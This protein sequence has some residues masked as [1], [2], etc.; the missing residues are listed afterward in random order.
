[1]DAGRLIARVTIG[2]LFVGHGTQKLF[3]WF[4]GSGPEGTAQMMDKLE[5][6]P[7]RRNALAAGASEAA[8]GA[9]LALGALTPLAGALLSGTMFTAIRKVHL[10][11]G[12][13]NTGGG[14]E[15][16]L[17]VV[18]A[19]AA[20]VEC[21]PG[22]PSV[23]RALGI[24]TSG[25]GWGLAAIA[26]GAAGSALAIEAGRRATEPAAGVGPEQEPAGEE[27]PREAP[28]RAAA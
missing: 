20:L 4:G 19:L 25:S 23:D 11:K 12:L 22:A 3:G 21:G 16:N 8:G 13:W 17:T 14:Y 18:A 24:D 5:L 7:A 2:G 27:S 10:P 26:A 15:Y 9:L 28:V 1:M 6:R